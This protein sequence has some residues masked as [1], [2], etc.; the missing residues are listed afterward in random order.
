MIAVERTDE[1]K[2][3]LLWQ[4]DQVR[5]AGSDFKPDSKT[6]D[7][8]PENGII[9]LRASIKYGENKAKFYYSLDNTT[10]KPLGGATSMSFNLSVFVGA[11]FGLFCYG[12]KTKGGIADFDWF[13]T[14]SQFDE[15]QV[16]P[17]EFQA[18]AENQFKVTK[19]VQ[20]PT[21]I[22]T[23]IGGWGVPLLK[24]TYADN[25]TAYVA[26][27]TTIVPEQDGIVEFHH[28]RMLG[29][30]QGSTPVK[31]TYVDPLGNS[32]E[33]TF[34]AKSSYF[35]FDYQYVRSDLKGSGTYRNNTASAVFKF[36]EANSQMGW[37]YNANVDMTGYKYLVIRLLQKQTADAHLNIYTTQSLTGAC[38]SSPKFDSR[39]EIVI[40]LDTCKYTSAA[41]KGKDL[42]RKTVRMITF[43]GAL[44]NK[45]LALSEMFLSNDP[46]YDT[47]GI[48]DVERST[49]NAQR[50][51]VNVHTLS[52]QLVRSGAPRATA[53]Q[54]LP[55]GVYI[56]DG[57][58]V[59][60]SGR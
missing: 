44:A 8:E 6:V 17:D 28:G 54:G 58:K 12:T 24:A 41:N 49:F 55:A 60:W 13:T 27:Q 31:A 4:Q 53:L 1:G 15:S 25:H 14:E 57:H 38:Y 10:W 7:V 40:D 20:N 23:M 34:T 46:K 52:G 21:T 16:C 11:R 47:T 29:T 48:L 59:I 50:S 37:V 2:F 32:V 22:E 5:D 19:L 51:K 18:P 3:Q 26:D 33:T 39:Q 9:Y 42:N 30:G 56:I 36:N 43:T 45:T 35:P